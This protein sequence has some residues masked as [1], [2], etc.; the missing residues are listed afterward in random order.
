MTSKALRGFT[1]VELITTIV[2]VG[3][4]S[5]VAIPRMFDN[6]AFSERGY[7]DEVSSA[8]SYAQKI[9]I[10]S[11]CEVSF[12]IDATGAYTA[13]QRSTFNN[14]VAKTG[15]WTMAIR[16]SDG[17]SLTGKP[18]SDAIL[19]PAATIVFDENGRVS[20][21]SPPVISV[22]PFTLTV[23]QPTGLVLVQP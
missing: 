2:I 7:I 1:L 5:A 11:R 19:T 14:C 13:N 6:S 10:A 18:P 16:R 8:L 17:S 22:G 15:P 21:G 9:A 3:I 12:A 20:N 4:L 23:D